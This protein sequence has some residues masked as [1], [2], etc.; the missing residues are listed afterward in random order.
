[1]YPF[2]SINIVYSL[3]RCLA[4]HPYP[5][6]IALREPLTSSLY[7]SLFAQTRENVPESIQVPGTTSGPESGEADG[8]AWLLVGSIRRC[9]RVPSGAGVDVSVFFGGFVS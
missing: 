6:M 5:I 8:L 7:Y 3:S 9:W 4:K 1:M 2:S